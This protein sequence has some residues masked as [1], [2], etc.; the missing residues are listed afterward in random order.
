METTIG[1]QIANHLRGIYFGGNWT[2][3]SLTDKLFDVSW[4][5]AISKVDSF[6]PI[7]SQVFHMNYFVRATIDVLEGRELTA[8]DALSFDCPE[9]SNQMDWETML[10]GSYED[11]EN[12][13]TLIEQLPDEQMGKTFVD[14]K[15]GSY[16]RCLH[17]PIE[18]CHYHLGQIS[19]IKALLAGNKSLL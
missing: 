5:Q 11:A 6:H 9:I 16:Y 12:L 1:Q 18:H 8:K 15:Y 2:A 17:G 4:E 14:E 19:I 3:V 7:A 10:K 13:A